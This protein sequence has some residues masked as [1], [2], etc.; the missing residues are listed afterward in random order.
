VFALAEVGRLGRACWIVIVLGA[1]FQLARFSEAF[2]VLR[3]AAFGSSAAWG[4]AALAVMSVVYAVVAYPA[5]LLA[6]RVD[7]RTLLAAGLVALIIADALLAIARD[8]AVALGGVAAWGLHMGLT[9]GVLSAMVAAVAPDRLRGTA[10]GV[11]SLVSGVVL[12]AASVLAGA[13]W[14]RVD[15]AATFIAGGIISLVALVALP[16]VP[17]NG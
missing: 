8:L 7:R 16:F 14:Q 10:F 4:P 3:V 15:P 17:R 1:V 2:L 6:D 9:Q 11:F 13:L 12:L 5:G